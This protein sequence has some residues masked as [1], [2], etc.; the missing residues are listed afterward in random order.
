MF[1]LTT[2]TRRR[3]ALSVRRLHHDIPR[4]G[5]VFPV[6]HIDIGPAAQP[7]STPLNPADVHKVARSPKPPPLQQSQAHHDHPPPES[8][9]EQEHPVSVNIERKPTDP[10]GPREIVDVTVKINP[11]AVLAWVATFFIVKW[12]W[13]R[14]NEAD[15]R[16]TQA[17]R[18]VAD[19]PNLAV[20]Q[21]DTDALAAHL[22]AL[23]R[24]LLPPRLQDEF[25][26]ALARRR[27][28]G[29]IGKAA[30]AEACAQLH[31][32]IQDQSL[33]K[34]DRAWKFSVIIGRFMGRDSGLKAKQTAGES[35]PESTEFSD[36][37]TDYPTSKA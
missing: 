6:E 25:A 10:D 2:C 12:F 18:L 16:I 29:E 13:K 28:Q 4:P 19:A 30:I 21:E 3:I 37:P 27:A 23:M 20:L 36:S 17:A 8:K 14:W 5:I 1:A 34:A 9:S 35:V 7:S 11:V 31:A 26:Q 15:E 24:V 22:D 32:T 33:G